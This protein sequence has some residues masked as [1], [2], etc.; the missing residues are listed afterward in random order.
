VPGQGF[1]VGFG[2][3]VVGSAE[4]LGFAED[5]G[6]APGV[7]SGTATR[8]AWYTEF[9]DIQTSVAGWPSP[10]GTTYIAP[11]R[12]ATA[13]REHGELVD[14]IERRDIERAEN[15]AR[16]HVRAAERLR[17][18]MISGAL[19]AAAAPEKRASRRAPDERATGRRTASRR[20][21]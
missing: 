19:E 17:L 7:T 1:L 11:G 14:A 21:K 10:P 16:T 8:G 9:P 20:T 3:A 4:P 12:A 5:E 18:L 6:L 15:V 13:L 2:V